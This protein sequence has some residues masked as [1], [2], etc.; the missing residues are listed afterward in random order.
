M[1]FLVTGGAGFIG[2]H[3]AETLVRRGE[4]VVIVDDLNSFYSPALKRANLE[5]V[6]SAGPFLFCQAD[7]RDEMAIERI[8]LRN[9][10]E[11][12]IHLAARAGVRPSLEEPVLYQDTNVRG[13]VVMLEAAR[14]FGAGKFLFA[15]SSSVYGIAN[16]VPFREKDRTHAPVSPYAATKLAGEMHCHAWAHLYGLK[17]IC[18]RFFTVYGPRQRPDLAIRKFTEMIDRGDPVTV[19]GNGSSARDYTFIE[20]IVSGILAAIHYD[21]QFDV[22]NLGN[23]EPVPLMS[24]I[25]AI[26]LAVGKQARL[27][28]LPE[29]AGDVPITYADISKARQ[30]LGYEPKTGLAEGIRRF[31]TA[32][33]ENKAGNAMAA[34]HASVRAF[35]AA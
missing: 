1:R 5:S 30:L 13:T 26:E 25:R 28:M 35:G 20:D 11:V 31:V 24:L 8:F 16:R 22:F 29:Q 14:R 32:H 10:P 6:G 9:R 34:H 7:I 17:A 19:F 4:E 15:S 12:V 23:S 27:K 21:S 3:V 2:S 33:L 18:L